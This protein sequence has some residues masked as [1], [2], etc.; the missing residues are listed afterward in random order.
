MHIGYF[1]E[2]NWTSRKWYIIKKNKF[3]TK[4]KKTNKKEYS[5]FKYGKC[6]T[7]K[8][9]LNYFANLDNSKEK[10]TIE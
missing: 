9:I 2:S 8:N 5:P 10:A 1:L 3:Y 7:V 6:I 4:I